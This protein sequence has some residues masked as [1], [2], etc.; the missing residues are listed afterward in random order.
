M[1]ENMGKHSWKIRGLS[2]GPTRNIG[3]M[4]SQP[5]RHKMV[6][7]L[8]DLPCGST[9][10]LDNEDPDLENLQSQAPSGRATSKKQ[11]D[12]QWATKTDIN[13]MVT[14]IK[15]FCASE[16]ATLKAD[17]G[18]LA[19]RIQAAEENIQSLGLKQQFTDTHLPEVSNTCAAL[20]AK[21]EHLE[22]LARQR[23]NPGYP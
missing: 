1:G 6:D 10:A 9:S 12:T 4:L 8:P 7:L 15:A 13:T 16:M 22:D 5:S 14:E 3:L 21:V 19:G 18:T 23:N 2:G 20:S 17:L 11:P